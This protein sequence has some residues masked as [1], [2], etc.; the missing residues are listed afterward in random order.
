[1]AI[2]KCLFSQNL[3]FSI[4]CCISIFLSL[5]IYATSISLNMLNNENE[6]LNDNTAV[7][8]IGGNIGVTL[9]QQRQNV[10]HF[11]A[12]LLEQV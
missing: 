1:M 11:A 2:L 5:P 8:P 6:G 10:I 3:F 4:L 12:R 9:G 7:A